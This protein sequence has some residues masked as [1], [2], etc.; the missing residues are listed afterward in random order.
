MLQIGFFDAK[1]GQD[2]AVDLLINEAKGVAK[3]LNLEKIIVGL[4][5]H[6]SY[7]VGILMDKFDSHI[8]LIAYIIRNIMFHILI[9]ADFLKEH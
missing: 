5:G 6:V 9:S 8:L 3:S 4:N 2:E 7:G 1:H